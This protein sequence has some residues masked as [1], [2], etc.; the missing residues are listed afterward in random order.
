MML[1]LLFPVFV[2]P[3]YTLAFRGR[4]IALTFYT[5]IIGSVCDLTVYFIATTMNPSPAGNQYEENI[6]PFLL[7]QLGA[8]LSVLITTL[9]LRFCG[10]RMVRVRKTAS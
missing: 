6:K 1:A 2:I 8:A 10:F 4:I 5:V 9:V 3:W 7:L